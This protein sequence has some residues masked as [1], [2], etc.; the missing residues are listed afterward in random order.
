MTKAYVNYSEG[1]NHH[2]QNLKLHSPCSFI[3]K[4]LQAD[5]ACNF[6][7]CNNDLSLDQ[8]S[9]LLQPNSI[10]EDT[11]PNNNIAKTIIENLPPTIKRIPNAPAYVLGVD[12][13]GIRSRLMAMKASNTNPIIQLHIRLNPENKTGSE[14]V[15]VPLTLD[16]NNF[17]RVK[18]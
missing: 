14:T 12:M 2:L 18:Q 13:D 1:D 5:V 7:I 17:I 11:L 16:S 9:V 3:T 6:T 4:V 15:T 8:Q 10:I